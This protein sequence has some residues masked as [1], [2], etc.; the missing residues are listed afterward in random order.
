M[1]GARWWIG[2]K[3]GLHY[4]QPVVVNSYQ[5][6]SSTI[7]STPDDQHYAKTYDKST[8]HSGYQIGLLA[9]FAF[10]R[11]IALV[12]QPTFTN[13]VFGYRT[14]YAW[15]DSTGSLS[16]EQMH[17][18]T[19]SALEVPLLL[20]FSLSFK[21]LQLYGQAGGY[22]GSLINASKTVQT[23]NL[24]TVGE[25][26]Q[27]FDNGTQTTSIRGMMAQTWKGLVAG[28]GISY[29]INYV[30][31]GLEC[32][33]H[34]GLD[35]RNKPGSRFTDSRLVAGAYDVPDDYRLRNLAFSLVL[36]MPL[37]NLIHLK[38]SVSEPHKHRK[39]GR[40]SF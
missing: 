20:R 9:G 30:R 31:V 39:M 22:Y 19:I 5:V 16:I 36:S 34:Y 14:N 2:L 25:T 1:R 10:T 13:S 33:Y 23:N 24:E 4:T 37:D 17:R 28:G 32:N 35:N 27:T 12:L 11:N 7:N 18:L 26:T 29:D 3:T 38:K 8:Q 40:P 21:K 15:R 6:F